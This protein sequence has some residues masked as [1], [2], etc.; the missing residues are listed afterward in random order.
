VSFLD[1]FLAT[2]MYAIGGFYVLAAA[3]FAAIAAH[4]EDHGD[5]NSAAALAAV[6]LFFAFVHIAAGTELL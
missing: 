5:R 1:F 2:V 4:A 3:W 6:A